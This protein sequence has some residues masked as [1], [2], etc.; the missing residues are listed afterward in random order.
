M[1]FLHSFYEYVI[2]INYFFNLIKI[3]TSLKDTKIETMKTTRQ[4]F[5]F[6]IHFLKLKIIIIKEKN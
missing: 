6:N 1:K 5:K 3:F 2:Y 4:Y